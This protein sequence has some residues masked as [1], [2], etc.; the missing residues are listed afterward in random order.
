VSG[1]RRIDEGQIRAFAEEYDP[2]PFHLDAEAAKATLFEG[3]VAIGWHTA[4]VTMRLMVGGGLPVAGGVVGAGA[5]VAWPRPVRPGAVL[6]LEN[7]VVEMR[8]SR[9]RPDRGLVKVRSETRDE[10]GEVVQVLVATSSCRGG[11]GRR[12]EANSSADPSATDRGQP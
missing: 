3:L 11:Y 2:Q 10:L 5:E 8:P 12:C 4:A 1:T 7:E 9:S 6:R